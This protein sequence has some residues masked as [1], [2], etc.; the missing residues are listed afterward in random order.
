MNY[1][2]CKVGLVPPFHSDISYHTKLAR[3]NNLREW[4][5]CMLIYKTTLTCVHY[6]TLEKLASAFA[7]IHDGLNLDFHCVKL[8]PMLIWCIKVV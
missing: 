7:L 3:C 1:V 2:G 6:S 5:I 8:I 4:T